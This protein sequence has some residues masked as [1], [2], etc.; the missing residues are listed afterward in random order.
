MSSYLTNVTR[1]D[2]S[3]L[4]PLANASV[5]GVEHL[6]SYSWIDAPTPTI[7]VPGVPPSWCGASTPRQL[8]QDSG[9]VYVAQNAARHPESPMEPLFRA[10]CIENPSFNL[11][12]VDIISDRN[13]IRKLLS[14][15]DPSS[16]A[17]GVK[18]FTMRMEAV[19]GTVILHREEKLTKEFIGPN[20]FRGYGHEFEKA[21]TRNEI[22]RSTGHHRIIS[23]FFGGLRFIIRHETDGYVDTET[24]TQS[25]NK[26]PTRDDLAGLLESLSIS[27][28]KAPLRPAFLVRS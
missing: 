11:F 17:H 22:S 1:P 24:P 3:R 19:N 10:L 23:Y 5:T 26:E 25:S 27:Q 13:N 14:F 20:K 16:A 18:S 6:A 4:A 12:S 9:F 28:S 8:Q 21:Y 15:I 2:V 7:A